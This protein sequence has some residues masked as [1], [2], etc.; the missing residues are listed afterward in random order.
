MGKTMDKA[1]VFYE[2]DDI[3]KVDW[4]KIQKYGVQIPSAARKAVEDA[5]AQVKAKKLKAPY[6]KVGTI[7]K[8]LYL[9]IKDGS[10]HIADVKL[11]SN[12]QPPVEEGEV[13]PEYAKS[14]KSFVEHKEQ[15]LKH[16][17]KHFKQM[18][19][20]SK[21]A[22][23]Q[24]ELAETL[25]DM[26]EKNQS[27]DAKANAV[28]AGEAAAKVAKIH[29]DARA[30]FDKEFMPYY[31]K[32][33]TNKFDKD[34]F[35]PPV[36]AKD[37][38]QYSHV[39]PQ[40]CKVY[41]NI[42]NLLHRING[43][44]ETAQLAAKEAT[45][46]ADSGSDKSAVYVVMAGDVLAIVKSRHASARAVTN[47]INYADREKNFKEKLATLVKAKTQE[48]KAAN[49]NQSTMLMDEMDNAAQNIAM[50]F[51]DGAI[52]FKGMAGRIPKDA[53]KAKEL[54]PVLDKVKEEFTSFTAYKTAYD[55]VLGKCQKIY[56][57]IVKASNK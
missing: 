42:D 1:D 22:E 23:S 31:D 45:T 44:E 35:D 10:S 49:L 41:K 29:T 26:C 54:K 52:A 28:K 33:R 14:L 47:K 24:T 17:D 15:L 19:Q 4:G 16:V 53:L 9:R 32:H 34:A 7:G 30:R 36:N 57:A 13:S 56:A 37:N 2:E 20:D 18:E 46:W 21:E 5:A 6:V 3:G 51:K 38:K 55:T 12:W 8:D 43:F 40:A 39:W 48:E 27:G 25:R 11:A 50:H